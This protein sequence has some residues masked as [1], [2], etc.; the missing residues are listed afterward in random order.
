VADSVPTAGD[1]DQP[2]VAVLPVRVAWNGVALPPAVTV[3]VVG[4]TESVGAPA[5]LTVIV[6]LAVSVPAVAV[7]VTVV[8]AATD[9]GGV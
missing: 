1:S 7:S 5:G 4:L 3:A 8:V 2:T 9:V 6:A